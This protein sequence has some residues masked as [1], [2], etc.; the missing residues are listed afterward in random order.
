VAGALGTTLEWFD[1]TLYVYLAPV[2]GELFFPSDDKLASL[3]A[4]FGVFA[5]GYLM[6]P[7]GA[8][9][10]GR[11]GDTRGRKAALTLSVLLMSVPML[12]IS[13]LPTHEEIGVAA[14]IL[15]VILR[16]VQGFS[17]GGEFSG[18]IVL[19]QESSG[20]GHRG[21]VSN[22]AQVTAGAGFLLSSL[23]ATI[24][25]AS[26]STQ[27]MQDWGWRL[28]FLLGGESGSSPSSSAAG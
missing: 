26:L 5:A 21:F 17:V 18:S 13:L 12:A 28:P 3:L 23:V 9:F 11:Y 7:L 1:F 14:P 22:L 10:F 20:P 2:I 16:L 19:L 4:T 15:L 24:L 27:Q 25:H 8:A 6:R